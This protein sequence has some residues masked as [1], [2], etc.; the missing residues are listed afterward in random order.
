MIEIAALLA[1]SEILVGQIVYSRNP[2][3]F[4]DEVLVGYLRCDGGCA[5]AAFFPTYHDAL[6]FS[7]SAS[8]SVCQNEKL[9]ELSTTNLAIGIELVAVRANYT[10]SDRCIEMLSSPTVMPI[11]PVDER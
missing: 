2:W 6:R 7:A 3:Y 4:Q 10:R 1:A 9:D 8:I 11:Y 5:D